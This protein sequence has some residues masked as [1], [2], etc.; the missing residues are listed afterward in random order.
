MAVTTAIVG[1][2]GTGVSLYEGDKQR[3]SANK[4]ASSLPALPPPPP[5]LISAPQRKVAQGQGRASTILTG[6][7]G[8]TQAAP[9]APKTLLGT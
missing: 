5:T 6:P 3:K 7:S 2:I 4:L 8:A 9:T 1:A